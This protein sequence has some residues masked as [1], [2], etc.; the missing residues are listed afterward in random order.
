[1]ATA[2]PM[3]PIEAVVK[4]VLGNF[5]GSKDLGI[6][7]QAMFDFMNKAKQKA[8]ANIPDEE[9][10]LIEQMRLLKEAEDT[11][12]LLWLDYRS[13]NAVNSMYREN[14]TEI[15][16][17]LFWNGVFT[18]LT[19]FYLVEVDVMSKLDPSVSASLYRKGSNYQIFCVSS[20]QRNYQVTTD[21]SKL[22]ELS[23]A[24]E[25]NILRSYTKDGKRLY[26][27]EFKNSRKENGNAE[28]SKNDSTT[29]AI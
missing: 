16:K 19:D 1:M 21:I 20:E 28:N 27:K 23:K 26:I 11:G 12:N 4:Q 10:L 15:L 8:V 18:R 9:R 5:E 22:N 29:A 17:P 3:N 14:F 24:M 6:I 13:W 2:S 25:S 7:G